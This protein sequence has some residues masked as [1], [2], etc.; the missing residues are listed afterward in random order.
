MSV[1]QI[2]SFLCENKKKEEE[3]V[4]QQASGENAVGCGVK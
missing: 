2:S 3:G 1:E 4:L